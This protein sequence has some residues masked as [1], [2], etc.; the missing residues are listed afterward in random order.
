VESVTYT[1]RLRTTLF[2]LPYRKADYKRYLAEVTDGAEKVGAKAKAQEF[3]ETALTIIRQIEFYTHSA[4][5]L[6]MALNYSVFVYEILGEQ[7]RA[8]VIAKVP[9]LLL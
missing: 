3:Y 4:L 7:N 9:I 8:M 6:G 1:L 2:T 5:Y